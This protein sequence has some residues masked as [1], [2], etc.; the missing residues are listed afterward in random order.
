MRMQLGRGPSRVV[1]A[2]L[3]AGALITGC[4]GPDQAGAAVI[5]GS[6]VVPLESVQSQLQVALKK[7][8]SLDAL[9]AQGGGPADVAR[10]IVGRAVI[11]DLLQRRAAAEGLAVSDAQ[12]D[13]RL[14]ESGGVDA[15][16]QSSIYDL[17][18]LRS[19]VRD[20]LLATALAE[21]SIGG[22]S[23]TADLVAVT[24]EADAQRIA[25]LLAA[26]GP[27]A[28]ALFG[29]PQT[30]ARGTAYDAVTSPEA[31]GT[32]LFGTPVGGVVAF[33]PNQR[34]ST[35]I[36]FRVTDRRTDAPF[37]QQAI[38]AI[39]STQ[40]T[41][42]GERLLQPD[43]D[44]IGVRVNPRYGVWDPIQL[45]VVAEDERAGTIML[46]GGTTQG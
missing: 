40:K 7:P 45:R 8:G 14:E 19:R 25:M 10:S 16:L 13:T 24:S 32:V 6:D 39:S 17:P 38:S 37:D 46:P 20:D 11:H 15:A 27:A 4:G 23:V 9:T 22:L 44:R 43:A 3:A 35:W 26:G 2:V 42:I 1:A 5:V 28:D 31:A 33:Q 36:V 41:T 29:D 12:V 30:S 18:T 34:Q 21:K